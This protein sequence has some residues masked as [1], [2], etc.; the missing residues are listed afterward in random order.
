[1]ETASAESNGAEPQRSVLT[2]VNKHRPERFDP[3]SQPL[4]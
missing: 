2:V 1:M 4:V 3:L